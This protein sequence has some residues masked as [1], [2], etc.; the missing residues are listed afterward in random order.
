MD[1]KAKLILLLLLILGAASG[2]A[3]MEET[4]ALEVG[5]TPEL[6]YIT[7]SAGIDAT[8]TI[9]SIVD[10]H[11]ITEWV[12]GDEITVTSGGESYVYVATSSGPTTAFAPKVAGQ[13]IPVS[14]DGT[15][16]LTAVYGG[17]KPITSQTISADGTNSVEKPL[18]ASFE[19]HSDTG[20]ISLNFSQTASLLE[21]SFAQENLT[22][23]SLVLSGMGGDDITVNFTGG[24]DLSS[25]DAS[26]QVV[27]G[28]MSTGAQNGLYM[29]ATLADDTHIGRVIWLGSA[30]S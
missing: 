26:V 10:G 8:K 15:Y 24:L 13:E 17:S 18:A 29:N 22:L 6:G 28:A 23:K 25:G 19:G 30:K 11:S 3:K 20:A 9:T 12:E 5:I 4:D 16:T 1:S 2:C 7:L 14:Q 21:L 27:M